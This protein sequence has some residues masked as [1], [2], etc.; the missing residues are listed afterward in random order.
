MKNKFII[1]VVAVFA[2][3]TAIFYYLHQQY[4]VIDIQA[5]SGGNVLMALLTIFTY[6]IVK[7]QVNERPQAF[8][9]GVYSATFLKLMICLVAIV[10]YAMF[11]KDNL[12]KPSL[13]ML[14]GIYVVYTAIETA[15][16]M[17]MAKN[18]NTPKN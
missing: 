1:T 12:H 10:G 14:F 16:L 3:L 15:T 6:F 4:P 5:L 7:K 17:K 11:N 8:V 18:D 2:C 13:F 9:R